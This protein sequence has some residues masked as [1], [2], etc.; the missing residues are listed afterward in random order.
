MYIMENINDKCFTCY[1]LSNSKCEF[2]CKEENKL[3]LKLNFEEN[4][5]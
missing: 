3:Q 5:S 2:N 1:F 4:E